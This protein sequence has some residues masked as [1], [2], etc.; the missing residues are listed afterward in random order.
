MTLSWMVVDSVLS[1]TYHD[2]R[3]VHLTPC[4]NHVT[5]SRDHMTPYLDP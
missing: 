3:E 4:H 5:S 2:L 1:L